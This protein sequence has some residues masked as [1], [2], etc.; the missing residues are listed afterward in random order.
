M[1]NHYDNQHLIVHPIQLQSDLF[2]AVASTVGSL[3][4]SHSIEKS[5]ILYVPKILQD[6]LVFCGGSKSYFYGLKPVF[7]INFRI[8]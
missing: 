2:W 5:V 1:T 3:I 7:F 8:L 4:Y 6:T